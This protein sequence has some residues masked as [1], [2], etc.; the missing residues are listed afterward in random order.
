MMKSVLLASLIAGVAAMGIS[1]PA[2]AWFGQGR[3]PTCDAP[4]VVSS[5]VNKFQRANRRTFGWGVEITQVTN[6]YE[7]PEVI[8]N[9]SLIGRRFCR[10][11]AIMTDGRNEQVA[12]LIETKQGFGSLTWRVES[13]LPSY[14]PWHVYGAWCRSIEP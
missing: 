13:C 14:D 12:Y 7:T 5:V 6:I 8:E 9:D 4:G 10:A 1:A 11:T 2:D 3:L